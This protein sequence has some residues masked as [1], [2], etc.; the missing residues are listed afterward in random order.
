MW[1]AA[2]R[3]CTASALLT[4]TS[5]LAMFFSQGRLSEPAFHL[6]RSCTP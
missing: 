1:L 5:S 6:S 4:W 2:C 3:T